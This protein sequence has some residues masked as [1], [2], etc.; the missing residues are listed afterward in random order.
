VRGRVANDVER[1]GALFG[2][3]LEFRVAIDAVARVDERAIDL[4][5]QRSLGQAAPIDAATSCTVTGFS[6]GR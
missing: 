6:N 5:G 3:D 1:V 4:A 2:D